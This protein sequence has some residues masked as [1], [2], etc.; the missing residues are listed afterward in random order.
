[1]EFQVQNVY[2]IYTELMVY[3]TLNL[4]YSKEHIYYILLTYNITLLFQNL[5]HFSVTDMSQ[6]H[7]ILIPNSESKSEKIK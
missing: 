2:L 6:C 5:L 4:V 3:T 1:M 7:I